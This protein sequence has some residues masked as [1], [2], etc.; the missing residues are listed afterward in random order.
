MRLILASANAIPL[1]DASV[2][3]C[4]TS[5]PYWGLRSYAGEQQQVWGGDPE[6][7]H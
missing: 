4:V 5:P 6:H 3:T 2:Q 1:P 7:T